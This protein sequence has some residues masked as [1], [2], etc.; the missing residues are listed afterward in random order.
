MKGLV[1]LV[2]LS[3]TYTQAMFFKGHKKMNFFDDS[4]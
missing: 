3:L 2:V 1:L 4:P